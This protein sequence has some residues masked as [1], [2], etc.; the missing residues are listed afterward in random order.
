MSENPFLVLMKD[1]EVEGMA[2]IDAL[3]DQEIEQVFVEQAFE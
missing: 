1:I 3:S 2:R